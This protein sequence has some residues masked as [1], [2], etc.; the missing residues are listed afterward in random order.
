M[1]VSNDVT[2][3]GTITLNSEVDLLGFITNKREDKIA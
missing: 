3:A 2:I 1:I